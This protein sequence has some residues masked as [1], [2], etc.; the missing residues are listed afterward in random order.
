LV[1]KRCSGCLWRGGSEKIS[2]KTM[3]DREDGV[4]VQ[5]PPLGERNVHGC[6]LRILSKKEGAVFSG[7][8]GNEPLR[9]D[10]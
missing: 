6:A 8:C 5:Y 4:G 3:Y 7:R 10:K 9:G 2:W 1:E